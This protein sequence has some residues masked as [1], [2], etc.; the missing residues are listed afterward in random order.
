[1]LGLAVPVTASYIIAAVMIAPALTQVGVPPAAAHMFIFYYAVLSEVSPPTALAPFAAAALTGGDPMRTTLHTWK[2]TI[3]AFVVPL[4]FTLNERG[5][6]LLLEAPW[7]DV[8]TA[9]TLASASLACF[10]GAACGWIRRQATMVERAGLTLC[11]ALLLQGSRAAVAVAV[12][13][14]AAT[15]GLHMIRTRKR[16]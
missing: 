10:A 12:V 8:V 6:G 16:V 11:G 3:P 2:Y 5:R 4:M 15:L 14:L 1:V 9:V 7:T 13:V